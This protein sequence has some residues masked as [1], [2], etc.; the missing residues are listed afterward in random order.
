MDAVILAFASGKGG[1]GKS[2]LAVLTG[3]AL[4]EMGKKV[5]VL[6]LAFGTRSVDAFS[7]ISD[8]AV[9]DIED[10]LSGNAAPARAVVESPIYSGLSVMPGPHAGGK[11]DS[12]R[13]WLLCGRLKPHFDYIILDAAPGCGEEFAATAGMAQHMVLVETADPVALKSGRILADMVADAGI[14]VHLLLNRVDKA[15]ALKNGY[16]QDLDEAIDITGAQL[17][18]VVP[19]SS[20]IQKST[21]SGQALPPSSRETQVFK[22]IAGRVLGEDIPLIIR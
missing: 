14:P 13:L 15:V 16:L 19:E 8:L 9:F 12:E 22:A 10:V 11:M 1:T 17:L 3:A 4:A 5:V 21:L 2:T 6:E 7:G 20:I 18:G